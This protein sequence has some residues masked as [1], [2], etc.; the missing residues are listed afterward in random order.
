MA[1]AGLLKLNPNPSNENSEWIDLVKVKIGL[2][3][4]LIRLRI[5]CSPMCHLNESFF[6]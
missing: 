4:G 5:F 3:G 1:A 2:K 6:C